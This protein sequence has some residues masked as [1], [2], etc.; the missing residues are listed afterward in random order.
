MVW[1][2][3]TLGTARTKTRHDIQLFSVF[4]S[5]NMAKKDITHVERI[6]VIHIFQGTMPIL[7]PNVRH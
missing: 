6:S 4:V 3:R 2:W 7:R 1:S 5:I